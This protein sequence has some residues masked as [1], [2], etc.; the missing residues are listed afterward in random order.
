MSCL[1]CLF[2]LF[3]LLW[4]SLFLPTLSHAKLPFF[5]GREDP[6]HI[7]S[8]VDGEDRETAVILNNST[9]D[10][11]IDIGPGVPIVITLGDSTD[12]TTSSAPFFTKAGSKTCELI[13]T[14]PRSNPSS[15][16][17]TSLLY[18]TSGSLSHSLPSSATTDHIHTPSSTS[19]SPSPSTTATSGAA[20]ASL[21]KPNASLIGFVILAVVLA[22]LVCAIG[23]ILW[24]RRRKRQRRAHI[25]VDLLAENKVRGFGSFEF[26][27]SPALDAQTNDEPQVMTSEP[28]VGQNDGAPVMTMT[29][30]G[31]TTRSVPQPAYS[32]KVAAIKPYEPQY[33]PSV[34]TNRQDG[35]SPS[36][37]PSTT[38]STLSSNH[39]FTSAGS[40]SAGY[41]PRPL[42]IAKSSDTYS[43]RS[44]KR[45]NVTNPSIFSD[46]SDALSH[47]PAEKTASTTNLLAHTDTSDRREVDGGV[48]MA[49][50]P[51]Q[52]SLF[53]I[54]PS[55]SP[56]QTLLDD[57]LPLYRFRKASSSEFD[58]PE[59]ASAMVTID[60]GRS[61]SSSLDV[62]S[63]ADLSLI[64]P[65]WQSHRYEAR[66]KCRP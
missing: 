10:W 63:I 43:Q 7:H 24:M 38:A 59:D 62:R 53:T 42:P 29:Y 36:R 13:Q 21:S 65:P 2:R 52:Q 40:S 26:V 64:R 44:L 27:R 66:L 11:D 30:N 25:S 46:D 1:F 15:E 9:F 60:P 57:E 12:Q 50:G 18:M 34:L 48:R 32:K 45:Y 54:I 55:V 37:Y 41:P 58:L 33:E 3:P 51:V 4:H 56:Y 8:E 20:G 14:S 49:G 31:Q 5:P 39:S 22:L 28:P 16:V 61:P 47:L 23:A 6:L 19:T 35:P 17:Q